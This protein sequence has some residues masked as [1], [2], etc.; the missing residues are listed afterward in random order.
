M[1]TYGIFRS[2]YS[3]LCKTVIDIGDLLPKCV[4]NHIITLSSKSNIDKC[5][6]PSEK[7]EKL[8]GYIAG[9]LQ[10]GYT[11]E[12]LILLKIMK[13]HGKPLTIQLANELE[14]LCPSSDD[15]VDPNGIVKVHK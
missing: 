1:A 8:L 14:S 9:P 11:K 10:E 12:F 15:V 2:N 4:S 6:S 5:S 3:K 13:D 7:V